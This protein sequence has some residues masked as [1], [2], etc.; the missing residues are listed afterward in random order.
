MKFLRQFFQS[1]IIIAVL[2]LLISTIHVP[3]QTLEP[4]EQIKRDMIAYVKKNQATLELSRP[5]LVQI[6]F[7][8]KNS[9]SDGFVKTATVAK[10]NLND[11]FLLERQAYEIL[12]QKRLEKGLKPLKWNEQLARVAR[13]HSANMAQFHFFSH[14]GLDGSLVNER[15]DALGIS[16]WRSIGENI[17]F[18]QGFKKPAE[19]ACQQWLNSPAHRDNIFDSRWQETGIGIVA[20][21]D[22]TFYFTQ[23]FLLK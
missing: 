11:L 7:A 22:G 16:N 5:R 8:E 18:N 4:D 19:S 10:A 12:N 3:G 1:L 23:V 2:F 13:G 20:A 15:A 21:A 6:N 9:G 17:A 14:T